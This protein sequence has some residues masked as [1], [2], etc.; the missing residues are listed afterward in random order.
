MHACARVCNSISIVLRCMWC[1]QYYEHWTPYIIIMHINSVAVF[2]VEEVRAA[3]IVK[4]SVSLIDEDSA[5]ISIPREVLECAAGGAPVRIAS[6][7]FR[8]VT[9]LLPESFS[10]EDQI[11]TITLV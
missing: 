6:F 1:D 7:L 9:G 2:R 11:E 3:D 8:N 5:R 10:D 4:N